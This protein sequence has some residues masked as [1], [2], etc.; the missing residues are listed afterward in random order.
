MGWV[1]ESGS[2][3]DAM[4]DPPQ[5][6]FHLLSPWIG[7]QQAQRC[8]PPES[9]VRCLEPA[10]RLLFASE[11]IGG[12]GDDPDQPELPIRVRRPQA[13]PTSPLA[14]SGRREVESRGDLLRIQREPRRHGL[15]HGD[16]QPLSNL[17]FQILGG[18]RISSVVPSEDIDDHG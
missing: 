4:L 16:G 12:L 15:Q 6:L 18:R 11:H 17:L 9:T 13:S 5:H 1:Q 7:I 10:R 3:E 2:A 14:R 8:L